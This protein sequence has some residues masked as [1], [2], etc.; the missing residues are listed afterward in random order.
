MMNMEVIGIFNMK[1]ILCMIDSLEDIIDMLMNR[2]HSVV[3]FFC[4]SEGEFVVVV[5]IH[6]V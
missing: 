5:E 1:G 2:N 3:T 6:G 4:S